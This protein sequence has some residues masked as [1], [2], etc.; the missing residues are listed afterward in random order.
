MML[1]CLG[2]SVVVG[3][4]LA[5]LGVRFFG[6]YW[7][8]RQLHMLKTLLP[9]FRQAN[10]DDVRQALLLK[11]GLATLQFSLLLMFLI[12]AMALMAALAPWALVWSA[13][14]QTIYW[15]SLSVIATGWWFF[16]PVL[17]KPPR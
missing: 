5:E 17:I 14:L 3:V 8:H 13:Q 1:F 15:V 16:R 6:S 10:D 2:I 7:F 12:T 4:F 9:A 11:S